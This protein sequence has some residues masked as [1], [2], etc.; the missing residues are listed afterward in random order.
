VADHRNDDEGR[1]CQVRSVWGVQ[2]TVGDAFY[3][4]EST[5]GRDLGVLAAAV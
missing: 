2:F 4:N 3:R 1:Q 5:V